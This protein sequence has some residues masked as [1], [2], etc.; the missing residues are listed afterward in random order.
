LIILAATDESFA[1]DTMS[2]Q[3]TSD[4]SRTG[5]LQFWR[6]TG[7]FIRGRTA[8]LAKK[9]AEL[10]HITFVDQPEQFLKAVRDFVAH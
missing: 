1:H 4:N 10:L 5:S 7:T 3:R 6:M 8:W 9:V 2:P